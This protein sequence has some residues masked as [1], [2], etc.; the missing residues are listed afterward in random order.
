MGTTTTI[1]LRDR[2]RSNLSS[3]P[4]NNTG[5]H[6]QVQPSVS[7]SVAVAPKSSPI[8]LG[9]LVSP[10]GSSLVVLFR[11][12]FRLGTGI[13]IK[14]RLLRLIHTALPHI[15]EA[16]ASSHNPV[17]ASLRPA[18]HFIGE[19]PSLYLGSFY[20]ITWLRQCREALHVA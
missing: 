18:F 1:R 20:I 6:F 16:L 12:R 7:V 13:G 5:Y 19:L 11:L 4:A 9:L 2:H 15:S 17:T 10:G 8:Y 14:E 3:R